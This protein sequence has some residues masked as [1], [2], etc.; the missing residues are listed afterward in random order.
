[1]LTEYSADGLVEASLKKIKGMRG[2]LLCVHVVV[3]QTTKNGDRVRAHAARAAARL[4]F[5][6]QS[7]RS[8]F[9][10]V[11]VAIA[12]VLAQIRY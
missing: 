3:W 7:I 9:S 8:L 1:M 4:F 2:L 12:F 10:G 5:L 11:V 6:I